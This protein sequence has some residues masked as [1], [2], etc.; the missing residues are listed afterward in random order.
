MMT[1]TLGAGLAPSRQPRAMLQ[2]AAVALAGRLAA[3][4]DQASSR[5][6]DWT[7]ER[8]LPAAGGASLAMVPVSFLAR[9]FIAR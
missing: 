4:W 1:L 3:G 8:L 6:E 2:Q 5:L 7:V 9:M